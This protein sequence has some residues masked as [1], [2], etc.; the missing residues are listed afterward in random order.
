MSFGF[1]ARLATAHL[2]AHLAAGMTTLKDGLA[3]VVAANC[4]VSEGMASQ[5]TLVPT[6]QG[7][8]TLGSASAAN[9]LPVICCRDLCEDAMVFAANWQPIKKAVWLDVRK[10]GFALLPCND[11]EDFAPKLRTGVPEKLAVAE[12]VEAALSAGQGDAH[13]VLDAE[14]ADRF[15]AVAADQGQD[16]DFVLF[17]LV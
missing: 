16:D 7:L 15:V 10:F 14:E 2:A 5:R 17:S 11:H 12:H 13:T 3:L 4:V 6:R 8:V 9:V 1:G